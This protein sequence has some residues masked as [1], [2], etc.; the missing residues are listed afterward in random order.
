MHTIASQAAGVSTVT[1]WQ[2]R[3]RN[4][5]FAQQCEEACKIGAHTIEAEGY[6]RAVHG[7]DKPIYGR[8]KDG[9]PVLVGHERLYDTK[10][11]EMMLRGHMP[12]RYQPKL[13]AEISGA[14][15][16]PL[17][18]NVIAPTIIFAVPDNGR[19]PKQIAHDIQALPA[20]P[21]PA[22][23]Q[24]RDR[25]IPK[26]PAQEPEPVQ[27]QTEP[28]QPMTEA[29]RKAQAE[30]ER[31]DRNNEEAMRRIRAEGRDNEPRGGQH[32]PFRG[33]LNTNSR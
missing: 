21:Q 7:W 6:R 12:E 16:A 32:Y 15:G 11:M 5:K 33:H 30:L 2:W 27:A 3:K 29:E 24:P 25:T 10:L 9:N 19:L 22:A 1:A 17:M 23:E 8:D 14:G 20:L 31:I 28:A 26:L 13:Q 4:A 18:P